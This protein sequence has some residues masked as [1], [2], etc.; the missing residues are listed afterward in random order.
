M[1]IHASLQK[2]NL[3]GG[4]AALGEQTKCKMR[5]YVRDNVGARVSTRARDSLR[6]CV[7]DYIMSLHNSQIDSNDRVELMA[8]FIAC[9]LRSRQKRASVAPTFLL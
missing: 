3:C 9:C 5:I 7:P 1:L 2:Q 8:S 4:E 6:V